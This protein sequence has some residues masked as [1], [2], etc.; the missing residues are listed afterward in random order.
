MWEG[1]T[2]T[3]LY[4]DERIVCTDRAIKI[5]WYYLWGPKRIRYS[6]IRA[7]ELVRMGGGTGQGRVWGTANVR[8]WA[9][10]DSQRRQKTLALILDTGRPVRPYLTPDD[11][12]AV[13]KIIQERAGLADIPETGTSPAV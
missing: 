8:Y 4:R 13:A 12:M 9:N 6:K 3:E 10:L 2:V 11:T 7:A 5:R 1:V